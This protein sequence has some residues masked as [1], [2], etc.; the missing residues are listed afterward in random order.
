MAAEKRVR[1]QP[2]NSLVP[3]E[4]MI[5]NSDNPLKRS[6][7]PNTKGSARADTAGENERNMPRASSMIPPA[8]SQPRPL[9]FL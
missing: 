8:I 9:S 7:N 6:Q 3:T 2:G 1:P 5:P 4:K